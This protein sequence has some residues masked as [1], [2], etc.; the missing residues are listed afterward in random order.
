MILMAGDA[1]DQ[2]GITTGGAH[3]AEVLTAHGIRLFMMQFGMIIAGS[4]STEIVPGG[5]GGFSVKSWALSNRE[6]MGYVSQATG[7]LVQ[8]VGGFDPQHQF[9]LNDAMRKRVE[10]MVYHEYAYAAQFYDFTLHANPAQLGKN[11]KIDLASATRAKK[12]SA[13][14]FYP[15]EVKTCTAPSEH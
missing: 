5:P 2:G 11:W 8:I 12:Q 6:H 1:D 10:W 14:L 13:E 9:E 15:Q 4:Y 7:G 3:A